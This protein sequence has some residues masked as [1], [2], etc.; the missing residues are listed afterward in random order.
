MIVVGILN[1]LAAVVFA[2]ALCWRLEQIRRQGGGL[3]PLAMTVAIAALTLAFVVSNED[4]A[5]AIDTIAF[6]GAERVL[7]FG[8]LAVGV[9]ALIVVF[10]FPDHSTREHRAGIEAIPLVA[11]IVGLQITMLIIPIDMRTESLSDWTVSNIAYALFVL[12]AS[13]YLAYG[14]LA[15][16]HSV[17]RFFRLADGYLKISL[18]LLVAGLMALALSALLQISF[19]VIASIGLGGWN[20]LLTCSQVASI[21]GV[22]GFLIGISY[23]M[24][25]ARWHAVTA[26]RRHRH[27]AEE[28]LPLWTLLTDAIPEVVL[29]AGRGM[30]PSMLLRRRVVE[31]R[32][33]L[34]QLSPFLTEDFDV[35]DDAARA[36]L[37]WAA[38]DEYTEVGRVRGAV[39]DVVP[40]EVADLDEDAA[41]LIRLSRA[42]A[43]VQ[44]S[45]L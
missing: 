38:V 39:R 44:A 15:C 35:V 28:L 3:Q 11:A 24:L 36:E 12:I 14:F 22:V 30:A 45:A 41:P 43:D 13:G 32:D 29:P 26:G 23:P 18:G 5:N 34:T 6:V 42:L 17:R 19:V 8:L 16:V 2:G 10:F 20:W 37:L 9:A 40:S 31:I 27:D 25:H 7:F 4:V 21:V 33:A 1:A